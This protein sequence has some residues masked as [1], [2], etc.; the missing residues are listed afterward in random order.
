MRVVEPNIGRAKVPLTSN[1]NKSIRMLSEA[2]KHLFK[3]YIHFAVVN[4]SECHSHLAVIL[5]VQSSGKLGANGV[6]TQFFYSS[7]N[8]V[9]GIDSR[10]IKSI[11]W[12]RIKNQYK[13]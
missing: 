4:T 9:S 10:D 1:L 12:E 6:E 7:C 2:F 5:N 3:K 11:W 8:A 13:L